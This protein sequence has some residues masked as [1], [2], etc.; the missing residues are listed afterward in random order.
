M[1]DKGAHPGVRSLLAKFENN[2]QNSTASPPPR[3]R[4]PIGSDA[5]GTSRPLSKVRASF[6]SVDRMSQ[7]SPV[8]GL[9]SP[10][11]PID[12]AAP[13][14]RERSLNS[15]DLEAVLKSSASSSS[16]SNASN[17]AEKPP[18][19]QPPKN[20]S[21]EPLIKAQTGTEP[22]A[23]D[24][25]QTEKTA[26]APHTATTTPPAKSAQKPTKAVTKR[27]SNV[28]V[29]KTSSAT[30]SPSTTASRSTANPR[31]PTS[32]AKP[33]TERTF[34]PAHSTKATATKDDHTA[35][36]RTA[37]HKPSRASLNTTA[38]T[39]TRPVRASIPARD[40]TK[41]ATTDDSNSRPKSPARSSRLP[42]S[43]TTSS[44][45]SIAKGAAGPGLTRKPSTLKSAVNTNQSR[46]T[47][48]SAASVRKQG[49]RPSLPA[50]SST[51]RPHSR[52]SNA[53]TK[54]VDDSFLARMMRPTASSASKVHDKVEI[55]SPPRTAKPA[56]APRTVAS[57]TDLRTAR[58]PTEKTESEKNKGD[59]ALL[60]SSVAPGS[61]KELQA[62]Q[63]LGGASEEQEVKAV[64]NNYDEAPKQVS[65]DVEKPV[66][67]P[68]AA[69]ADIGK[70]S[71]DASI[72]PVNASTSDAPLEET[73][74]A[75]V[76]EPAEQPLE[77]IAEQSADVD[78]SKT[79]EGAALV[80]VT[81]VSE[82]VET[83]AEDIS[84]TT[85]VEAKENSAG[86]LP[87][88]PE[89]EK[90]IQPTE[91]IPAETKL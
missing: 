45:S 61:K 60:A 51:D 81:D 55:K 71:T 91:I 50:H 89:V 67:E 46:A 58:P 37:T 20:S 28:S 44:L 83:S 39:A 86:E 38:K 84:K 1:S 78:Q 82:T 74:S 24:I 13:P 21:S 47:T 41:P 59:K 87:T 6:I 33:S 56:R 54:P 57:K 68:P 22:S 53:S 4:S 9:R 17:A 18:I 34:K 11:S 31:T 85:P 63:A 79:E 40:S 10:N 48:P 19:D 70:E 29:G 15:E 5:T 26:S 66:E 88:E 90:L 49:S 36:T 23:G 27:P 52:V 73:A 72:E 25:S 80:S 64:A 2:H 30:K 77:T 35:A 12:G 75:K 32:P 7:G 16:P 76:D 14:S 8:P 62:A 42:P 43:K 69:T 65:E 3:G